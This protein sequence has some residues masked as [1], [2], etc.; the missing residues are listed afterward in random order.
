MD[1]GFYFYTIAGKVIVC[2]RFDDD[3]Q[4]LWKAATCHVIKVL[5]NINGVQLK[6]KSCGVLHDGAI[7]TGTGQVISTSGTFRYALQLDVKSCIWEPSCVKNQAPEQPNDEGIFSIQNQKMQRL[8]V[9]K[10]IVHVITGEG[11]THSTTFLVYRR[12]CQ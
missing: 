8:A 3:E 5:Q 7:I 9:V 4:C 12:C 1:F 11:Q 6:S 2:T 10:Y